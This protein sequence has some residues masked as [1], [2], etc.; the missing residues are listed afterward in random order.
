MICDP[1][2]VPEPYVGGLDLIMLLM[3]IIL[4][5][6][7]WIEE[8]IAYTPGNGDIKLIEYIFELSGFSLDGEI[9]ILFIYIPIW[10]KIS[11][12]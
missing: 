9:L 10:L 2:K 6:Q 3:E 4:D 8:D 11:I 7:K 5:L 1:D 12:S